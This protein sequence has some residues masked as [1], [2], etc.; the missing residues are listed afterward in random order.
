MK[1]GGRLRF[2]ASLT[3]I[4]AATV[5]VGVVV[6][7]TTFDTFRQSYVTTLD[8]S[9][10]QA[11]FLV[12]DFFQ[13]Q[14]TLLSLYASSPSVQSGRFSDLPDWLRDP[15]H[16]SGPRRLSILD[17]NGLGVTSTGSQFDAR[18]RDY[19][20][21]ALRGDQAIEGPLVSRIDGRRVVAVA[22]PIPGF[23]PEAR[24]LSASIDLE[25]LRV[26]LDSVH[27][28]SGAQFT[29][30]NASGS[31]LATNTGSR[32]LQGADVLEATRTLPSQWT[33]KAR[34]KFDDLLAPLRN[35]LLLLGAL[36][37]G[38]GALVLSIY[39]GGW[40]HRHDLDQVR[41]DR[42]LALREAYEQIRK[43]AFHDTVTRLP[44]RNLILRRIGEALQ[45]ETPLM[46]IVVALGRF[47]NLSTTFG[48]HFGDA[49]LRETAS[50]LSTYA[51]TDQDCFLGRLGGSEFLL[52]LPPSRYTPQTLGDLLA[53]FEEPMGRADLKLHVNVHIGACRIAD[54]GATAE[55]VIKGA[56]TALWTARE[57]GDHEACELDSA[58][59]AV[60]LRRAQ[61]Q[62]LLPEAWLRGEME[63]FF[64]PQIDLNTGAVFGYE[65]L[66][67]WT[68]PELGP[69]SP[70]EFIPVAEETGAIV[71][72]GF[73]VL[74]RGLEFAKTLWEEESPAVVSVNVSA[75]QF[76]HQGFLAEVSRRVEALGLPPCWLGLEITESA[77]MEGIDQLRPSLERTMDSGVKVSLD[78]FGTGYSSLNYLKDL[79][80]H[81]L[82][83]DRSFVQ[84]LED[85]QRAFHLVECIIDL[86]HH[87]GLVVVAEGIETPRQRELL[88]EV[89][90][91]LL[92][93]YLTGRPASAADHLERTFPDWVAP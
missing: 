74:D 63:V 24:V 87:L 61:L 15:S 67:R 29:L 13:N 71:P 59:V 46:V 48:I 81:T 17:E 55:D 50:R 82:K 88:G 27:G 38:A 12:T 23:H 35:I 43:L 44:N 31:L 91:D 83:I 2:F 58:A 49:I 41:E 40:R 6:Y 86:A 72:L 14:F 90:C 30:T 79:P 92:Q 47:R 9:V 73:W 84:A 62:K 56:E 80:L 4:L 70:A 54:G 11:E 21:A 51:P 57:R 37:V 77:L 68:S 45:A 66:S 25:A 69:V 60:R 53:L 42:T 3:S 85:D 22:V 20:Q 34:V 26:F 33:L 93:G 39:L 18:D 7:Q 36:I 19:F 8:R 76:L 89:G 64:Q 75:V 5:L 1:A 78:D 32:T 65:A 10:A 28:L 16:G 52:L